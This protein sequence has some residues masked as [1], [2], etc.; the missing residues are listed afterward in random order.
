MVKEL[1]DDNL[2]HAIEKMEETGGEPMSLSMT[3]PFV[4]DFYKESPA[5]SQCML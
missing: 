1:L 3:V 4:V 2:L 5:M